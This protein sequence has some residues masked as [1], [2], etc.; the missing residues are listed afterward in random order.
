MDN[1]PWT[2]P[3]RALADRRERWWTAQRGAEERAMG[4]R[5]LFAYPSDVDAV[6]AFR[7]LYIV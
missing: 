6:D 4:M 7:T 3:S 5:A 1:R 2:G